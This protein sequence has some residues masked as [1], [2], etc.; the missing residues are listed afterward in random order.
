MVALWLSVVLSRRFLLTVI[1]WSGRASYRWD[2]LHKSWKNLHA[3][4][5][6]EKAKRFYLIQPVKHKMDVLSRF[7]PTALF[8]SQKGTNL[9]P[10]G[11]RPEEKIHLSEIN[12][13]ID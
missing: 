12:I 13:H 11:S 2:Q 1:L 4:T 8:D 9:C 10:Q 7:D 5:Q 6:T 3:T